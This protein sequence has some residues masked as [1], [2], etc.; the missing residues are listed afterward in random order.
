MWK[1]Q[2]PCRVARDA[3]IHAAEG[4]HEVKLQGASGATFTI[5]CEG[6]H[7]LHFH[8]LSLTYKTVTI[9]GLFSI[10]AFSIS[11]GSDVMRRFQAR[12]ASSAIE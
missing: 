10:V 11:L 3:A 2:E 12:I 7:E 4:P 1:H 5:S 6:L 9:L 8:Y